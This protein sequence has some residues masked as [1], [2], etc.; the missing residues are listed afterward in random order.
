[1]ALSAIK[2]MEM[3]NSSEHVILLPLEQEI[4]TSRPSVCILVCCGAML[5]STP[6]PLKFI[7]GVG[8]SW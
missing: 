2:L 7:C 5:C 3:E 6:G 4:A 8:A 1:M